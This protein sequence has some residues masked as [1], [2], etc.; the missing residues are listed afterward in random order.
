MIVNDLLSLQKEVD[1]FG[2]TQKHKN[3]PLFDLKSSG[4]AKC[5]II[6]CI[7]NYFYRNHKI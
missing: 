4:C 5:V 6:C 1:L 7:H 3:V 2:K